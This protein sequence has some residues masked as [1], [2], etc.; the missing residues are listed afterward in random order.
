M[1]V[2]RWIKR[3][4]P[5]FVWRWLR[6]LRTRFEN[7]RYRRMLQTYPRRV[8]EH[9]YGGLRLKVTLADP[10]GAAWYDR[11]WSRLPEIA[12]LAGSR[13]RPEATVFNVGAHQGVVALMLAGEVG[14]HGRVVAV[15]P[16]PINAELIAENA[17]L[18][19]VGHIR[20]V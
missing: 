14:P 6:G 3:V 19:S 20:V 5:A 1:T 2:K 4:T 18:N 12:L 8:V 10:D 15:D 16:N 9:E 7:A 13:L 11:D 17:R